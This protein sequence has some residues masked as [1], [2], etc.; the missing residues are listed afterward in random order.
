[1]AFLFTSGDVYSRVSAVKSPQP[2]DSIECLMDD[3][4]ID[5]STISWDLRAHVLVYNVKILAQ[6]LEAS[7]FTSLTTVGR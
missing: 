2:P 4:A 7:G 3:E 6:V 5:L 1:M